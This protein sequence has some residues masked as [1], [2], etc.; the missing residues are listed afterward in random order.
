MFY[1]FLF[2]SRNSSRLL[3]CN[4]WMQF[5]HVVQQRL[6]VFNVRMWEGWFKCEREKYRREKVENKRWIEMENACL[7]YRRR[8]VDTEKFWWKLYFWIIFKLVQI[9]RIWRFFSV[10]WW[11]W[12][13]N[14][15]RKKL[16]RYIN[17]WQIIISRLMRWF[18]LE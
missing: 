2:V 15:S 16:S 4:I 17:K 8:R 7:K 14:E 3:F 6:G 11:N 10:I 1:W 9:M 13:V 12:I 5:L 18:I